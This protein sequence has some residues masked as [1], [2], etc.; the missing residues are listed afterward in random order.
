MGNGIERHAL[1]VFG[2]KVSVSNAGHNPYGHHRAQR[3]VV[4]V[5]TVD[6]VLDIVPRRLKGARHEVE[7]LCVVALSGER[8]QTPVPAIRCVNVPKRELPSRP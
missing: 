6:Q 4:E 5:A 1:Q 8:H 3:H 7:R 2:I